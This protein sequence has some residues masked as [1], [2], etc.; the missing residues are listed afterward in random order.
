MFTY[1]TGLNMRKELLTEVIFFICLLISFAVIFI[2]V[3]CNIQSANDK[4]KNIKDTVIGKSY[5]GHEKSI[6][7]GKEEYTI[8]FLDN[9]KARYLKTDFNFH[10]SN[11]NIFHK[12]KPEKIYED[13]VSS[14]K[15]IGT[16]TGKIELAINGHKYY[17]V[18]KNDKTVKSINYENE[19]VSAN[20]ATIMKKSLK[21]LKG[22]PCYKIITFLEKQIS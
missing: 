19:T 9:K 7:L 17:V 8:T 14:Y 6:G 4:I 2:V 11:D 20:I 18:L 22:T 12:D 3:R 15:F 21:Y 10:I 1:D 5:S 13:V 16:A